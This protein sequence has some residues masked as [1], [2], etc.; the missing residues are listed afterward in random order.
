MD[1]N[2]PNQDEVQAESIVGQIPDD[3]LTDHSY[4]GIQEFDNPL[5]GWWKWMFIGTIFFA[6]PYTAFYHS[7]AEGRTVIERYDK[8]LAANQ[9]LQFAEIG[10]LTLDRDSVIRFLYQPSWLRV[11]QSVYKTHCV[12]CHGADGGGLVGPNLTDDSYKNV[13][14][15]GDVLS[16]IENGAGGGAMPAWKTRLSANEM[17]LVAS[18]VASLRGTEAPDGKTAEGRVI[19]PWPGPP[20]EEEPG[21]PAAEENA[22]TQSSGDGVAAD[23]VPAAS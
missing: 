20:A 5:P 19:A 9:R 10:E 21:P 3:P 2:P 18:Y 7:G 4:D 8:A 13:N 6:F 14:D 23:L 15:I 1:N 16:V 17:V 12:S 11:G 22:E